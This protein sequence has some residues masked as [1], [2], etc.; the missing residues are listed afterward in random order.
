MN[1]VHGRFSLGFWILWTDWFNA[2]IRLLMSESPCCSSNKIYVSS[3]IIQK[4]LYA[5]VQKRRSVL[6]HFIIK[7]YP[8]IKKTKNK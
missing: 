3:N 8:L 6:L 7:F 2:M 1:I 4:Y 5:Y